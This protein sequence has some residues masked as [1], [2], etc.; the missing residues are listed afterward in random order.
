MNTTTAERNRYVV[1]IDVSKDRLDVCS[2]PGSEAFAV[3]NDQEGI[4]SLLLEWLRET[5]PELVVLWRP[6]AGTSAPQRRPSP[7]PGSRLRWSTPVRPETSPGPRGTARQDRPTRDA[8]ILARFAAAVGPR[9]SVLPEEEAQ[10]LQAI[11]TR[12]RQLLEMLVAE[13]NRLQMAPEAVASRI[14]AHVRWLEKELERTDGRRAR[15]GRRSEHHLEAQ[16]D[17][18]EEG[19]RSGACARPHA[20]CGAARARHAHP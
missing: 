6:V 17:A 1:G 12:R 10:A 15:G 3:A 4:D 7:P 5:C 16:R 2:V 20:A 13:N 19:A 8:E 14:R 18:L 11:L 9:P